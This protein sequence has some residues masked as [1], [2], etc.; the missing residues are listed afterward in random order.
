MA[1][2]SLV[3]GNMA[4]AQKNQGPFLDANPPPARIKVMDSLMCPL[5]EGPPHLELRCPRPER[6]SWWCGVCLMEKVFHG[7]HKPGDAPLRPPTLTA[8]GVA[9]TQKWCVRCGSPVCPEHAAAKSRRP[10]CGPEDCR[11]RTEPQ[12]EALRTALELYVPDYLEAGPHR[13]TV[14]ALP[15]WRSNLCM[16]H[17][18]AVRKGSELSVPRRLHRHPVRVD[19]V[20][21]SVPGP[22]RAA[23]SEAALKGG[24]TL[25]AWVV[26]AIRLALGSEKVIDIWFANTVF[27]S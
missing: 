18:D 23:A 9:R 25:S 14:C 2:V 5:C 22:I 10:R 15:V 20:Q 1:G 4:A 19:S 3:Q 11:A 17:Y 24:L 6:H 27:R 26:E 8:A 7:S 16:R 21:L 13:C 12:V